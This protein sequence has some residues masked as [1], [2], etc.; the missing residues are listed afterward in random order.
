MAGDR[1][2]EL[3]SRIRQ[4]FWNLQPDCAT[5]LVGAND[6]WHEINSQNGVEIDR[7]EN[8]Y[9]LIIKETKQKFPSMRIILVE[10]F[11]HHGTST[12]AHFEEFLQIYNYAN[13]V[14]NLAKEFGLEFVEL[15]EKFN[16]LIAINGSAYYLAD[17]IHPTIVGAKLI[18][19][20]WLKVYKRNS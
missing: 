2:V 11:V 16:Q 20:E 15:Q 9:R 4:D 14:K 8:I 7:F 10:P 1:I 6:V 5:I 19:E 17:G 18:A 3:Y 13:V 12:E